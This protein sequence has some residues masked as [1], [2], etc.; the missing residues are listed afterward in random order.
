MECDINWLLSR[1][2]RTLDNPVGLDLVSL[3]KLNLLI[4]LYSKK[5]KRKA[6][7]SEMCGSHYIGITVLKY[8]V[9]YEMSVMIV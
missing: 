7:H 3:M 5:H 4:I 9:K 2:L 6:K 1:D 8:E